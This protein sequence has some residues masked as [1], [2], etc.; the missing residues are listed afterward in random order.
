MNASNSPETTLAHDDLATL[1][2]V[3]A[4][5]LPLRAAESRRLSAMGDLLAAEAALATSLTEHLHC[6]RVNFSGT[7]GSGSLSAATNELCRTLSEFSEQVQ[8]LASDYAWIAP[9]DGASGGGASAAAAPAS[10]AA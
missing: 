4:M 3:V 9:A 6:V 2:E 10:S 1:A 8:R 7:H 5:R